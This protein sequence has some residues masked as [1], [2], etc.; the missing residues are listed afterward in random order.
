MKIIVLEN[1]HWLILEEIC[2]FYLLKSFPSFGR[3]KI[4]C[5]FSYKWYGCK[6]VCLLCTVDVVYGL[7]EMLRLIDIV[8]FEKVNEKSSITYITI[9]FYQNHTDEVY[10]YKK[11]ICIFLLYM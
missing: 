2:R 10:Y 5:T 6:C 11:Y 9:F 8:T 1:N 7:W 3:G 4:T